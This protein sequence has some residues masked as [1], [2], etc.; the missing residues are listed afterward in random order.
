MQARGG[1]AALV[2]AIALAFAAGTASAHSILQ[3]SIPPAN[4]SLSAP[5]RQVILVFSEPVVGALSTARMSDR[6][7]TVVSQAAVAA[8]DGRTLTIS[9]GP[10]AAGVYTVRWR[11]LSATDGHTTS[12]FLLFGVGERLPAGGPAGTEVI[13]PPISEVLV[14]WANFAAAILLAGTVFFQFLVLR[15]VHARLDAAEVWPAH[16]E[17]DRLL[18]AIT[19]ASAGALLAGLTGE[20]VLEAATLLDTPV[21]GVWRSGILWTLLGGTKAGWS[22]LTRAAGAIVLLLPP[23]PSGRILG[24]AMLVWCVIVGVLFGLLGGP[25]ALAGSVHLAALVLVASVYGLVSVMAAVIVPKIPDA[26]I[27]ELP[28][29]GCVAASAMLAGITVSSHAVGSG[30]AAIVL[31]WLHL[32]GT[33]LWV[34]GLLPLWLVLRHV[35][36]AERGLVARVLVPRFSRLAAIAVAILVVTGGYSAL[37]HVRSLQAL[38]VTTYGRTLLVK[39][40][41]V[42]PAVALGAY[43]RFVLRPR[44]EGRRPAGNT[45]HRFLRSLSAEIAL[46]AA[47]LLVVAV[48]TITPPAAVTM[49]VP[50]RPPL[51]LAGLAGP[52]RAELTISPAEP[53]WNRFEAVV[54]TDGGPMDPQGSRILL[55]LTKL[56][57]DLDPVTITLQPDAD[58]FSAEG[59]ELGVPGMWEVQLVV[60]QRGTRDAVT[61]FPLRLGA[62]SGRPDVQAQQILQRAREAA[63]RV[64][65][66]REREQI[67]DGS[68]GVTV[69]D[70]EMMKPD[71]VH[72]RTASGAEAIIIGATRLYRQGGGSWERDTLPSP[73]VLEGPYVSYLQDAAAVSLG[74]T[75]FCDRERCRV[76]TWQLKSASASFAAWVGLDTFRIYRLYMSA[77][78]HYMTAQ[79]LDLNA[80]LRISPP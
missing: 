49:P 15:P 79:A 72:Y 23:S 21:A 38:T 40:L 16:A 76:V 5:P 50:A 77:P 37:V 32:L 74:R 73:I 53:G 10:L 61:A 75:G 78:F 67:T 80:P 17:T 70:L 9:T 57:E 34:G 65:T 6:Q 46:G 27:P 45:P 24:A 28:I 41:L 64:R 54:R 71:R 52:F 48:L 63:V 60:R 44:M 47:I 29:V 56:D 8:Q 43:H 3:R 20:F 7:G 25:V 2:G 26:V 58:R 14:R 35:P 39:L 31:D 69:T 55:R 66:W 33:S 36:A 1:Y 19:V 62:P 11:V 4:A 22:T 30:P 42:L 68:G 18:R 59:S 12:G 13:G 51:I